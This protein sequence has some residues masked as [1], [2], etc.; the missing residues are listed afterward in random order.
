LRIPLLEGRKFTAEDFQQAAEA[1]AAEQKA[2]EKANSS[3]TPSRAATSLSP[4]SPP[5]P[6]LV[7]RTFARRYLANQNPLGKLITR[8]PSEGSSGDSEPGNPKSPGWQIA[9]VVGDTKYSG[10]RRK[11]HPTVYFPLTGGGAH[12]ELRTASNP[13]ALIPA[14]REAVHRLDSNLPVTDVHT[15]S[16]KI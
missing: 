13:A 2:H 1:A 9:G 7:N 10:L 6:V 5:I 8:G 4:V 3:Q 15:Q 11:I 14:V 16:Q 12:F